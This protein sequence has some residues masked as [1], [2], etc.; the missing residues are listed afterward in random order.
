MT[1]KQ[2]TDNRHLKFGVDV[3]RSII[4]SKLN[5][6]T[7]L[8]TVGELRCSGTNFLDDIARLVVV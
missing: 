3:A 8:K 1:A 2:N 5:K 4:L 7:P 6:S